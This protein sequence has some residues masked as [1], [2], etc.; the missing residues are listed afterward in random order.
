M[1]GGDVFQPLVTITD[2]TAAGTGATASLTIS[3]INLLN[4][5]QEVYNFSDIFLGNWP[6]LI[7]CMQSRV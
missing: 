1:I 6:G 7:R 5:G 2:A 4:Q 3:P